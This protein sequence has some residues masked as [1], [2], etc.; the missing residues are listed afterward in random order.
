[1]PSELP[2]LRE[3]ETAE[4]KNLL[5]LAVPARANGGWVQSA[6]LGVASGRSQAV[7]ERTLQAPRRP[8]TLAVTGRVTEIETCDDG[9]VAVGRF[10]PSP[11]GAAT[12]PPWVLPHTQQPGAVV[13]HRPFHSYP[14]GEQMLLIPRSN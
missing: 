1:M 13:L 7:A 5:A 2:K 9:P 11:T 10:V 6:R 3:L 14:A 12:A 8:S 4:E